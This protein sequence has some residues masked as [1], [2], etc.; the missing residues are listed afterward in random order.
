MRFLKTEH[1]TITK[2]RERKTVRIEEKVKT[3]Y[4]YQ[5]F[6]KKING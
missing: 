4:S 1:K 6:H 2:N 5:N 3:G